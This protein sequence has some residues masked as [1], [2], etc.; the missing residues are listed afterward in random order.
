VERAREDQGKDV[1]PP[2][3]DIFA[4][5]KKKYWLP[6]YALVTDLAEIEK[7]RQIIDLAENRNLLINTVPEDVY[8]ACKALIKAY[9]GDFLEEL[10]KS[11]IYAFDPPMDSWAREP[12]TL[13][14]D[15]YLQAVLYAAEY[16]RKKGDASRV[17][18]EQREHYAEAGRLFNDGAI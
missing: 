7:Q 6:A 4:L 14:R 8:A 16:E 2:D 3:L 18:A 17:P 13:F 5:Q 1:F 11:N 12:F 9:T 10:L 15:Y